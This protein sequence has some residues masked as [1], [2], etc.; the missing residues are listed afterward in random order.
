MKLPGSSLL[1]WLVPASLGLH[2]ALLVGMP[3]ARRAKA[4][5]PLP[6]VTMIDAPEPPKAPEPEPE[7]K[8]EPE[9]VLPAK[10]TPVAVSPPKAPVA[11]APLESQTVASTSNAANDVFVDFTATP[12]SSTT[13][14]TRAQ[15]AGSPTGAPAA[16]TAAPFVAASSLAR[17]PR[18]PA[19]LDAELERNYP[20]GARRAGVSGKAVLRVR[21]AAD[22]RVAATTTVSESFEGFAS[23]C[24]RTVRA[25]R[26]EPPVDRD[27]RAVSTEITYVCRFEVRS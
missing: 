22:G 24:E 27:G 5:P 25:G 21:I 9:R 11:I 19:G 14:A 13:T 23:A 2:A 8:V 6:A 16:L 10:A 18:S 4:P 17:S 3:V 20:L 1:P 26:W 7:P 12:G 15:P